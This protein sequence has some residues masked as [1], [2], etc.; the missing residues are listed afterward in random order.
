[1]GIGWGYSDDPLPPSLIK[2]RI[3]I[4]RYEVIVNHSILKIVFEFIQNVFFPN[5]VFFLTFGQLAI[6]KLVKGFFET[7]A[8]HMFV[9]D[10]RIICLT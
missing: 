5:L 7:I 10:Q 4:S 9:W 2:K 1:M 6:Q 3:K 8:R